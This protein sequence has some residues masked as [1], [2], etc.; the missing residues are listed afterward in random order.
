MWQIRDLIKP[1]LPGSRSKAFNFPHFKLFSTTNR[2]LKCPQKE[3][4]LKQTS[5]WT[6][7]NGPKG[8]G[9]ME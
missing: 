9:V 5:S 6:L 3:I 2:F 8:L 1:T 7:K 4:S